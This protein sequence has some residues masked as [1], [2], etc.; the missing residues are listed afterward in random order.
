ML[1]GK[2]TVPRRL[3]RICMDFLF[4]LSIRVEVE[5]VQEVG[6]Q[7][8]N[9]PP[10]V[11]KLNIPNASVT[12][13]QLYDTRSSNITSCHRLRPRSSACSVCSACELMSSS[14]SRR[15]DK[16]TCHEFDG[17]DDACLFP[18]AAELGFWLR[19]LKV[20]RPFSSRHCPDCRRSHLP[21]SEA[22]ATTRFSANPSKYLCLVG[23]L[24]CDICPLAP[25]ALGSR[26]TI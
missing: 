15:V 16:R 13:S 3:L 17:V 19:E 24:E 6:I 8:K 14:H 1:I 9:A 21:P 22:V 2:G 20:R 4:F 18:G 7:A 10:E 12:L 11:P 23:V 26:E 5:V 25:L